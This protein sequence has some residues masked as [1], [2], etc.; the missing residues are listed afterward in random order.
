MDNGA[1]YGACHEHSWTELSSWLV[2]LG[3]QVSHGR[4]YHPQTQGKDERLHRT[5][6]FEWLRH[7]NFTSPEH[8]QRGLYQFCDL[9]RLERPHDA[10]GLDTP[11]AIASVRSRY[12]KA[13]RR[14]N[15]QPGWRCERSRATAA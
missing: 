6:K 4:A 9:Y 14:L 15:I 3:I 11:A 7:V 2:R 1:P 12:P 5:L 8:R 13:S 10:L